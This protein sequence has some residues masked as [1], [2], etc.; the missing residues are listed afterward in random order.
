MQLLLAAGLGAAAAFF[1]DP[2]MGKGRRS[3]LRDRAMAAVRR[4]ADRAE[5]LGQDAANRAY[6]M[7]H[8]VGDAVRPTP[9][10][11]RQ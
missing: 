10:A 6:G 5:G 4:S 2:Q 1:F 8:E 9:A 3:R 7:A 11:A